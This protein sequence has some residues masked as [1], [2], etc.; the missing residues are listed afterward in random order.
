L[1]GQ[2]VETPRTRTRKGPCQE[3][4][5]RVGKRTTH[6]GAVSRPQMRTA[7]PLDGNK[8]SPRY[9]GG[10]PATRAWARY[11]CAGPLA[12]LAEQRTFN[13]RVR[14]SSPRRP[15]TPQ[16][17]RSAPIEVRSGTHPLPILFVLRL[18]RSG[19]AEEQL[20]GADAIEHV[21]PLTRVAPALLRHLRGGWGDA[22]TRRTLR[23]H[24][25][26][27]RTTGSN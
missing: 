27:S 3:G 17:S 2:H 20:K 8:T 14:G 7:A 4:S 21:R 25:T 22:V 18:V 15:T 26:N 5:H 16:V 10:R 23:H 1:R 11:A 6:V 9:T 13:P 24:A 12:Q 19:Q